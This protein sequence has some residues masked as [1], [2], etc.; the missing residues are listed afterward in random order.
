MRTFRF[1]WLG[2]LTFIVLLFV[3]SP[4]IVLIPSSLTSAKFLSFPPQGFSFQWYAKILDRPE[5]IDSFIFSIELAVVTAIAATILGTLAGF[6]IAKYKF[7]GKK[8]VN[9]FLLSP[10]SVPSLIVGIAVL[11]YF[12]K[13]GIAGSFFGLLLAHLLI[14][15]PYVV[16]LV[17]TGMTSFDYSLEKAAAIVGAKPIRVFWDITLPLIRPAVFSGFIFSFLNSFD[18]VTLS[19]FL[20]SPQ[21]MTLPLTIFSYI[22]ENVDPLISAVSTAVILLSLIPVILLEKVYGLQRLFGMETNSH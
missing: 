22:Q 10:L 9:T 11:I 1:S 13:I 21:Q 8:I 5:F 19:L 14:T 16:R 4:F 6:S 15:I 18:N 17:L 3:I 7:R 20:V 12:T 2:A